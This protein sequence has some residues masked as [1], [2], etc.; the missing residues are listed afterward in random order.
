[1]EGCQD[2]PHTGLRARLSFARLCYLNLLTL[3]L[4]CFFAKTVLP[5]LFCL[6]LCVYI[7]ELLSVHFELVNTGLQ[8]T[9]ESASL[10]VTANSDPPVYSEYPDSP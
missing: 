10:T 3:S 2:S 9:L 5:A 6:F 4:S 7:R 1:M 8:S